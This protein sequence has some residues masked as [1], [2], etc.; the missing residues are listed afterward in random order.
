VRDEAP[1]RDAIRKFGANVH[2]ECFADFEM[3]DAIEHVDALIVRV[4]KLD[5]FQS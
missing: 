2:V 4:P 5:T 1:R 3:L